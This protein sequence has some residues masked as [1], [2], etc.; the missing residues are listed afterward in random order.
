MRV[1]FNDGRYLVDLVDEEKPS[2]D[3]SHLNIFNDATDLD[4]IYEAI[5]NLPEDI[6][7]F[8]F[9]YY[10]NLNDKL[11]CINSEYE[12]FTLLLTQSSD[13]E[14]EVL[15]KIQ[16]NCRLVKLVCTREF[17]LN[18]I[19]QFKLIAKIENLPWFDG[20]VPS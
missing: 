15:L 11:G 6:D 17:D 4:K 5:E 19:S 3:Q 9:D 12:N 20:K 2:V 18:L 10:P 13:Y 14:I 1:N 16:H 7:S 8:C